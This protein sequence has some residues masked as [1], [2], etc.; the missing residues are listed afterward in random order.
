MASNFYLSNICLR[1]YLRNVDGTLA[2]TAITSP[3]TSRFHVSAG[4]QQLH[5]YE[6]PNGWRTL[7]P[8]RR[9]FASCAQWSVQ[10]E[11]FGCGVVER[12]HSKLGA[13]TIIMLPKGGRAHA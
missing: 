12:T 2:S 8:S 10:L 5:K 13:G 7:H 6:Y 11:S 1:I 9:L 3:N 4:L